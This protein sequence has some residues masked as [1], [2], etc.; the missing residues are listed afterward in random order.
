MDNNWGAFK[1]IPREGRKP[2]KLPMDV[3]SGG[4]PVAAQECFKYSLEQAKAAM[5]GGSVELGYIPKPGSA[6]VGLDFDECRDDQSI[7]GWAD[8]II[9]KYTGPRA[10]TP[11][12]SGL[13]I[14]Q[15][16]VEGDDQHNSG[17]ANNVGFFAN[18]GRGFTVPLE[19]L[20]EGIYR[21]E[22]MVQRL[23]ARKGIIGPSQPPVDAAETARKW[24]GHWLRQ[25]SGKEQ[26]QVVRGML[27]ALP[28]K[29]VVEYD[30]WL[31]ISM[32][33]HDLEQRTLV[34]PDWWAVETL[35]DAWCQ[36]ADDRFSVNRP[37]YDREKNLTK[38]NGFTPGNTTIFTLIHHARESGFDIKP[39]MQ[40]AD[41]RQQEQRRV[42]SAILAERA[43]NA[44][45]LVI[46]PVEPVE[47]TDTI[48]LTRPPGLLG[49]IVDYGEAVAHRE[50]RFFGLSG[51]LVAVAAL[52]AHRWVVQSPN[53]MKTPLGLHVLCA[54]GTG[55][56]K[57]GALDRVRDASAASEKATYSVAAGGSPASEAGLHSMLVRNQRQVLLIDEFGRYMTA[58][59]GGSHEYKIITLMMMLHT[60]SMG[61]LP[62]R[63]YSDSRNDKPAIH[64]PFLCGLYATTPEVLLKSF[65]SSTISDGFLGRMLML[66]LPDRPPLRMDRGDVDLGAIKTE[67]DADMRSLAN[68][69]RE[70]GKGLEG[71]KQDAAIDF[72]SISL[73]PEADGYLWKR[74]RFAFDERAGE[75][76]A[77]A[78]LWARAY[79]MVLRIAGIVAVGAAEDLSQISIDIEIAR[80][81]AALVEYSI[82]SNA[83]DVEA[84]TADGEF[85]ALQKGL[86]R[87]VEK[88]AD[89]NGEALVTAVVKN[90]KGRSRPMALVKQELDAMCDGDLGL[91]VLQYVTELV[92]GKTVRVQPARVKKAGT[93]RRGAE[94]P[95]VEQGALT[96]YRPSKE[97]K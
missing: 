56:G 45:L 74:V 14:L 89:A 67:L 1:I 77:T 96:A 12:G 38:W 11:S 27:E 54:A 84:H 57:E 43:A 85:E 17:E 20:G 31:V 53:G 60:S 49:R 5:N 76:G 33:L 66:T 25:L 91:G 41:Q 92:D 50:T 51:G 83:R 81:A 59:E 65:T 10:V 8:H 55:T 62:A 93:G 15:R 35:W 52:T 39:W 21:D 97:L 64:K 18:G 13:R 90:V 87:S 40:K 95:I 72:H 22:D 48:D 58:Q 80:Y 26:E 7:E 44:G 16:R 63:N 6:Y 46:E 75:T 32:A 36:T 30:D 19:A 34:P 70:G 79:E 24:E 71:L 3:A 29:F 28:R 88:F 86:M 68:W 47:P 37:R 9:G 23:L 82:L 61:S 69:T 78:G 94:Q 4:F 73:T 42:D 2:E